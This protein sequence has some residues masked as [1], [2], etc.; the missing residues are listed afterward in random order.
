MMTAHSRQV[1]AQVQAKLHLTQI[2]PRPL[3][4]LP[5]QKQQTL[6]LALLGPV[7]AMTR[8]MTW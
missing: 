7:D 1:K 6:T 2:V 8:K 3:P 4:P 5:L